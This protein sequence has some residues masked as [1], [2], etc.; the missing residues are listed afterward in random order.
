MKK[1]I[2][3]LAL[4][5]CTKK[6]AIHFVDPYI[7]SK[8][9]GHVFVG[10]NVPF[11]AVQLGP[12]QIMRH[13]D[14]FSGWDWTSGYNYI[15]EEV[16]GFTHTHLSGT[17]I[18]DL[19]DILLLPA[20][21]K[22]QLSPMKIGEPHSG[23]GSPISKKNEKVEPG[24]YEVFLPKY[25]V[26]A[27][28]TTTE[29]VGFHKY[30]FENPDRP[31]VLI[32][33]KFGIGWDAPTATRLEQIN[34]TLWVGHR[35]STGW[36]KDQKVFFALTTNVPAERFELFDDE[37][38]VQGKEG[39]GKGMKGVIYF[40]SKLKEVKIKVALSPVSYDNA[41][42]NMD[43]ELPHWNF[44]VVKIEAQKKWKTEFDKINIEAADS[45]KNIFY[46]ALYHTR[47]APSLFNDVN[48]DYRGADQ[49][50]Y[51]EAKFKNY[52]VFSLW[53]TYRS[54]HPLLTITDPNKSEDFVQSLLHQSEQQNALAMWPLH[55]NETFTM[56]GNPAMI[57]IADAYRKG[58][59]K[60]GTAY[61]AFETLY[62][63]SNTPTTTELPPFQKYI[64][65]LSWIP[66]DSTHE[67]VA[68]AMEYAVADGAFA[69]MADKL[70]QKEAAKYYSKR[71]QLYK[72]Y[73]DPVT[74]FFRGK[75][76]DSTFSETFDPFYAAHRENDYI[77]G[78]AWQYLWMVPHQIPELIKLIGG[79]QKTEARLDQFF[80]LDQKLDSKASND[81]TGLIGQYAHGNEPSHHIAYIYSY[82]GKHYK[83][84]EKV[85]E[86]MSRFYSTQ[87]DGLVGNED[88]GQMSAWYIFNALGLYPVDPSKDFFVFGSP[89]VQQAIIKL[90]KDK[91][92]KITAKKNSDKNK[93][94]QDVKWNGNSLGKWF[95]SYQELMQGGELEFTMGPQ[96]SEWM[97]KAQYIPQ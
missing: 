78:N 40:P 22:L 44:D 84:A 95:I 55:G 27:E 63:F 32:D 34:D 24:Y 66:A 69:D 17:G 47:F 59:I 4:L 88:V 5:S 56:V 46:T 73:F 16:L 14:E 82:L 28:L 20:N 80:A 23:Y 76:A 75:R 1:W 42:L 70:G 60:L 53:D 74:G 30:S 6:E 89:V 71:A 62:K 3:L 72:N 7:G 93:Y 9:H 92:L 18:G 15:S 97:K 36:A 77:E 86:I 31:H 54:L 8:G 68:W 10:A 65:D 33:L 58:L 85:R 83:T 29:R 79:P 96:P 37:K 39:F 91:I 13:W 94:I 48:G 35:F 43:K 52:T 19:N 50:V 21:G 90:P 2:W 45:I 61:K 81:I 51:R 11:G 38:P 57:V 12:S 64:R 25:E 49:K 41:R 26:L 67:T 87:A